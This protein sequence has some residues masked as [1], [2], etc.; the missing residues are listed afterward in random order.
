LTLGMKIITHFYY[1]VFCD[2]QDLSSINTLKVQHKTHLSVYQRE[3][4][5]TG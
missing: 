4:L 1:H 5:S 2:I 3:K